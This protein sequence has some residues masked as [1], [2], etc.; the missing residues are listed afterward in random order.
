MFAVLRFQKIKTKQE[1]AAM[2]VHWRRDKHTPNADPDRK[3][4]FLLGACTADDVTWGVN[5]TKALQG[6][7]FCDSRRPFCGLEVAMA[8]LF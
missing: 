7:S 2:Y 4:E 5:R 3:I 6:L 8:D 1:I